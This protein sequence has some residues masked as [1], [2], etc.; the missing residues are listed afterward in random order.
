M[1]ANLWV[2][3]LHPRSPSGGRRGRLP[4]QPRPEALEGRSMLSGISPAFQD[5]SHRLSPAG[6]V[7][8][9]GYTPAQVRAAYRFDQISL[10]GAIVGNGAGQTIAIV[11]AYD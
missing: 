7:T 6:S 11:D 4:W 9:D 3:S 1:T 2:R 8:P 5:F 10:A